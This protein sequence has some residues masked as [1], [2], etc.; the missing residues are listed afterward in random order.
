MRTWLPCIWLLA[1]CGLEFKLSWF[2][3]RPIWKHKWC[4]G[5]FSNL[6][7]S[8]LFFFPRRLIE[9]R[10]C[11]FANEWSD[12][13]EVWEMEM[14][15]NETDLWAN[16]RSKEIIRPTVMVFVTDLFCWD[17]SRR[18]TDALKRNPPQQ[19]LPCERT[20]NVG[21]VFSSAE[22][23]DNH[24]S[25]VLG[26]EKKNMSKWPMSDMIKMY[27]L[28]QFW[29]LL[30]NLRPNEQSKLFSS[31]KNNPFNMCDHVAS[32]VRALLKCNAYKSIHGRGAIMW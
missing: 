27:I 13:F 5:S 19:K 21:V 23:T 12:C 29:F 17:Y 14:R 31:W 32:C 16:Y 9:A 22:W 4:N 24:L 7:L 2:N 3:Y 28:G 30:T 15:R 8:Q 11:Q 18:S 6:F 10:K 1:K 20:L 25:A 26:K